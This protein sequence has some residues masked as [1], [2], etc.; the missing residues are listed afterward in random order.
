MSLSSSSL[1]EETKQMKTGYQNP[2]IEKNSQDRGVDEIG[3]LE[4]LISQRLQKYLQ[5]HT[6]LTTPKTN[7]KAVTKHVIRF[8]STNQE[9]WEK[10]AT[11][12]DVIL[13]TLRSFVSEKHYHD[14]KRTG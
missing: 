2:L 13:V 3:L 7:E 8:L 12:S 11:P 10:Q 4:N 5:T 14:K 6:P 9:V 1:G